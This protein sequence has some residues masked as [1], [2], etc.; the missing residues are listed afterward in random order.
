MTRSELI[1]L[2][3]DERPG[4]YRNDI[5]DAVSVIFDQISSSLASGNRV[6]IR[7]FGIFTTKKHL[8]HTGRNPRTGAAVD[9]PEKVLPV[10][11]TGKLLRDKLN[12]SA[13]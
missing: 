12:A 3:A 5:E 6:E 10:Y 8:A 1:N 7:G 4:L 11:K 2:L 13:W 9:V